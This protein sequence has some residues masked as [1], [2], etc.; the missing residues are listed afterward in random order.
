MAR[1]SGSGLV[2]RNGPGSAATS[3]AESMVKPAEGQTR[4]IDCG[5]FSCCCIP[6]P[7]CVM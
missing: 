3:V 6:I 5:E 2:N 4:C 7:C 1:A